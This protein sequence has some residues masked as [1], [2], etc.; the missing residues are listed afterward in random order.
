MRARLHILAIGALV[1]SI[2]ITTPAVAATTTSHRL[3]GANELRY[4]IAGDGAVTSQPI[5]TKHGVLNVRR[6]T[7]AALAANRYQV[8]R[9]SY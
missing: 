1:G 2:G 4:V 6:A 9:N 8:L 3:T 5:R 7:G